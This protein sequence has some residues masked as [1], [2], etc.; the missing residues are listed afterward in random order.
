D[1]ELNGRREDQEEPRVL[2]RRRHPRQDVGHAAQQHGRRQHGADDELVLLA[3]LLGLARGAFGVERGAGR[4][5][6]RRLRQLVAR[7][8][9]RRLER[10]ETGPLRIERDRGLLSREVN[11][12]PLDA[13]EPGE[14]ALDLAHTRRTVHA[15]QR[16]ALCLHHLPRNRANT[17]SSSSIF[18]WRSLFEPERMASVTHDSMCR[19][20]R[21]FSTCS[22]APCTAETWSRMST[23]YASPSIIRWRPCTC[24]SI[25]RSRPR[26][27]AF[28]SSLI[29]PYTPR[30]SIALG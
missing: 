24:P 23:Q 15:A 25:R 27:L 4:L 18:C 22:S 8:P 11:A 21:S 2:E 17:S 9:D 13:G 7:R 12:R 26:A 6:G 30:G 16:G 29:I 3:P 5:V 10:V 14:G 20:S 1:P 19:P 28:V